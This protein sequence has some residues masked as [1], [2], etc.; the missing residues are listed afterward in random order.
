[1]A[2]NWKCLEV[3]PSE[4]QATLESLTNDRWRVLQVSPTPAQEPTYN[5]TRF[6]VVSYRMVYEKNDRHNKQDYLED[7]Q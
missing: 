2:V 5:A 4:L 6:T 1:M 3:L 7:D